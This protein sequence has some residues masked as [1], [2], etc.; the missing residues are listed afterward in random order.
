[1]QIEVQLV[2]VGRCVPL[3]LKCV[4]LC[5]Y[6]LKHQTLAM[7]ISICAVFAIR[8]VFSHYFTEGEVVCE[9]PYNLRF[10]CALA[11]FGT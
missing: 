6:P 8:G 10:K 1:M 2:T 5:L 4:F 11:Q 9:L 3:H 7:L